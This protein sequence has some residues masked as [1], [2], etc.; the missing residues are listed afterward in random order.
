MYL[1]I[2]EYRIISAVEMHSISNEMLVRL[3]PSC[4]NEKSSLDCSFRM[5]IELGNNNTSD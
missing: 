4:S 2:Y 1:L 5:S 3:K